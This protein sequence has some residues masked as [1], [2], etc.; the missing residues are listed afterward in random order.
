MKRVHSLIGNG[1]LNFH[2]RFNGD[3]GNLLHYIGRAEKVDNSLVDTEFKS[4]PCVGTYN[5]KRMNQ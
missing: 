3:G 2:T 1:D 4:V 5:K